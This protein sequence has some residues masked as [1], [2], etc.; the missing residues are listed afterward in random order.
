M[1]KGL[2]IQATLLSLLFIIGIAGLFVLS[3]MA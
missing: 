3:S 2:A 1:L